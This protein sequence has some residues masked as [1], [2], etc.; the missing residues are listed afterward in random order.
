M[1]PVRY[2]GPGIRVGGRY[3]RRN[4]RDFDEDAYHQRAKVE[5]VFSVE[6]RKMGSHV[7]AR[8]PSQQHKE[9]IFRAFSYNSGRMETLFLLFIEDFYKARCEA[10][11]SFTFH[12]LQESECKL[13]DC[14][15]HDAEDEAQGTKIVVLSLGL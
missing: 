15:P 8:V 9:L 3:R 10:K 12:I 11:T 4:L 13:H 6:K 2:R 14:N 5:T 7:L 1:I